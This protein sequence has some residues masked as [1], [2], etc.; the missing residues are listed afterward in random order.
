MALKRYNTEQCYC[1]Y[2]GT[3]QY[4]QS[5]VLEQKAYSSSHH[6]VMQVQ[7]YFCMANHLNEDWQTEMVSAKPGSWHQELQAS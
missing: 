7:A 2:R 4:P 1:Q 6:Y 3:L 5:W